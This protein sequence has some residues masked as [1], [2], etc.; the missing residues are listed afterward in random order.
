[1]QQRLPIPLPKA[2]FMSLGDY[3]EETDDDVATATPSAGD[4]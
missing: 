2:K 1:M 4:P 3:D